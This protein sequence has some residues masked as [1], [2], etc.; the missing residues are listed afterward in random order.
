MVGDIVQQ[1]E[2][3]LRRI[4]ATLATVGRSRR[5]IVS[6]TCHLVRREDP[7]GFNQAYRAFFTEYPLPAR[8]TIVTELVVDVLIKISVIARNPNE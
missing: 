8:A 2:T 5:G 4:E 6:S 1:T 7:A 3:V